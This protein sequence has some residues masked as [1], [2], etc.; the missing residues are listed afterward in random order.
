VGWS[1]RVRVGDVDLEVDT[2]GAGEPVVV[3]QTALDADELR[4]LAEQLAELGRYRSVH[5]HRRGYA[6]SSPFDGAGSIARDADDCRDLISA[7]RIAPAHLVGAS[8]GAAVALT[9]ASSAPGHVRTLTVIEPPPGHSDDFRAANARLLEVF[10]RQGA[11]VA[12]DEFMT[13]LAGQDWRAESERAHAGSVSALERHAAD[14]MSRRCSHGSSAP[15]RRRESPARCCT[16]EAPTRGRCSPACAT[17][18]WQCSHT[19]RAR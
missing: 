2:V 7:L 19:P 9:L 15:F 12:L 1:G 10:R 18:P 6:R 17:T 11:F 8:Y 4:P 3:I 5:Y 13:M 14:T 16:W